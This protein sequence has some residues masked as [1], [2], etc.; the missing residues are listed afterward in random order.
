MAK[1]YG[2]ADYRRGKIGDLLFRKVGDRNIVSEK[3]NYYPVNSA[4]LKKEEFRKYVQSLVAGSYD[5]VDVVDELPTNRNGDIELRNNTIYFV[6]NSTNDNNYKIYVYEDN[7]LKEINVGGKGPEPENEIVTIDFDDLAIYNSSLLPAF[8]LDKVQSVF[9]NLLAGKQVELKITTTYDGADFNVSYNIYN[10]TSAKKTVSGY[11]LHTMK[12]FF[13]AT[14]YYKSKNFRAWCLNYTLPDTYEITPAEND[15]FDNIY[16][17]GSIALG[18]KPTIGTWEK[19]AENKTLWGSSSTLNSGTT[20]EAGLPNITGSTSYYLQSWATWDETPNGVFSSSEKASQSIDNNVGTTYKKLR[21][22]FDASRS[23][24]IYGK[25]NTVQPPA[26][27]V[28]MWIRV[29]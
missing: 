4:W 9:A 23:N 22:N 7:T 12:A 3:G 19:I 11:L 2:L 28:D 1:T 6:K 26:Y 17:V 21:V 20:L 29:A 10:F 16:P 13:S 14:N 8:T 27:V 24:S 5:A 25:S 15:I 18:A